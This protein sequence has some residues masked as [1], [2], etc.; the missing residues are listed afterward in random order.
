M[1]LAGGPQAR[2]DLFR[3]SQRIAQVTLQMGYYSRVLVFEMLASISVGT[4]LA[5]L[6][7]LV[8]LMFSVWV[9]DVSPG[10]NLPLSDQQLENVSG[11]VSSRAS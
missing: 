6:Y 8:N 3:D 10:Y 1:K 4:R 2:C 11:I 5:A 9:G 7:A